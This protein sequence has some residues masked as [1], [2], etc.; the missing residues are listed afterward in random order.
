VHRADDK[1]WLL[2]HLAIGEPQRFVTGK[3]QPQVTV[4]IALEYAPLAVAAISVELDHETRPRPV[5]I[6]LEALDKDIRPRKLEL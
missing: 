1:V 6:D 5:R 4:V 3:S 2:G